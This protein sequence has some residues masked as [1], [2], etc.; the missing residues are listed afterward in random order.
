MDAHDLKYTKF[1]NL[2]PPEAPHVSNKMY[3]DQ[4]STQGVLQSKEYQQ[5][6]AP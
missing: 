2:I 5:L 6:G 4:I 3:S 1:T